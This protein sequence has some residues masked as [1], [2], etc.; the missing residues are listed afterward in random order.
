MKLSSPLAALY[1]IRDILDETGLATPKLRRV[2]QCVIQGVAAEQRNICTPLQRDAGVLLDAA[3]K[4]V[5]AA[6]SGPVNPSLWASIGDLQRV[7]D[8]LRPPKPAP[9]T[10]PELAEMLHQVMRTGADAPSMAAAYDLLARV[11]S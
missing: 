7:V 5:D 4:V 11:Q 6:L 1:A 2:A 10:V 8:P 9:A 3:I